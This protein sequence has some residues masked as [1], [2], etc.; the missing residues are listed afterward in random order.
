MR[1]ADIVRLRLRSVFRRSAVEQELDEELRYHL[2]SEIDENIA[3]GMST[4]DARLEALRS[5]S[6]LEQR[7]EECRDTRGVNMIDNLVGDLRFAL[8]QLR[9]DMEFTTTAILMLALG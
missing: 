8:R 3:L 7:K 9:R 1:L 2:Q 4:A 6:G 5:I